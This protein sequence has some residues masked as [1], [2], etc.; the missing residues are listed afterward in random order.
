VGPA[1]AAALAWGA[2]RARLVIGLGRRPPGRAATVD[3]R[4]AICLLDLGTAD[5]VEGAD[6]HTLTGSLLDLLLLLGSGSFFF[7]H[8]AFP[9]DWRSTQ[10]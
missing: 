10:I 1:H 2:P 6:G 4:V 8:L 7:W 5:V 9:W 3:Y